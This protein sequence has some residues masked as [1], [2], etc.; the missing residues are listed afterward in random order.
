MQYIHWN[1]RPYIQGRVVKR[2]DIFICFITRFCLRYEMAAFGDWWEQGRLA[3]NNAVMCSVTLEGR[4]G[5][6][7]RKQMREWALSGDAHTIGSTDIKVYSQ[8]TPKAYLSG[9]SCTDH[10]QQ[11]MKK[12]RKGIKL[13][14]SWDGVLSQDALC[15]ELCIVLFSAW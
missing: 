1:K 12:K 8:N 10:G 5:K 13:K 6:G 9:I 11:K 15:D 4:K 7:S 2:Q 14:W 3:P